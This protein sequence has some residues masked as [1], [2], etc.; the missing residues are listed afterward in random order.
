VLLPVLYEWVKHGVTGRLQA[1]KFYDVVNP[2]SFT[3][4]IALP[5]SMIFFMSAV[6]HSHPHSDSDHSHHDHT[7]G[8]IDPE[9][10]TTERGIWAVTSGLSSA[11]LSRLHSKWLS[12]SFLEVWLCLPTR[13]TT[14]PTR[15]PP[16]LCEL[17]LP[18]RGDN[19]PVASLTVMAVWKT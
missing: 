12:S 15:R 2:T 5:W 7:H 11:W 4:R 10:L 19:P 16:F 1:M 6:D 18:W 3:W 14:L 17:R 9:L 13:Y 8:T